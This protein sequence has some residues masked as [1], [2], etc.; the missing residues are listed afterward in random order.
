MMRRFR[1]HAIASVIAVCTAATAAHAQPGS[2]KGVFLGIQYAGASVS[3]KSAAEDLEFG[4]GFGLHAGIGLSDRWSVLV[5]FDRSVLTGTDSDAEVK[6][7]QYDALLRLHL[8]P[9]PASPL[10]V[11]ATAGAT[12]RAA[13]GSTEFEGVAPTA[14][15]GV[16]LFL[17]PQIAL[18]GTALWTFGNLTR[19]SE[20]SNSTRES[21]RSTGTR[22][23]A[24]VSLY[25]FSH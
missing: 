12:G 9:G 23:Q 15:A 10:R 3:V 25:L 14:G 22:V 16:H 5:N 21:F 11:F 7:S 6:L 4:N 18:N 19:A 1:S 13:S 2:T 20:L 17:T 24:G 8:F